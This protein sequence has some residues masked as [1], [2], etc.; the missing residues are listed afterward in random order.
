MKERESTDGGTGDGE[1]RQKRRSTSA[2]PG[3]P[4][5]ASQAVLNY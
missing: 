1:G 2:V 5:K 3:M 4:A